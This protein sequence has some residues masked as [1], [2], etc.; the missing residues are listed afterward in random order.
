MIGTR[1]PAVDLP[2]ADHATI[3][4]YLA[5]SGDDNPLHRLP[6]LA[7]AAGY[8]DI[9]VPGMLIMGQ[10]AEALQAWPTCA[11]IDWILCRFVDP[12]V[13]G[14]ALRCEG[15]ILAADPSGGVV[16]RLTAGVG[17]RYSVVCEAVIHL[18]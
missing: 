10:M 7:Q 8:S 15:R 1:L 16:V 12:V 18:A 6:D 5:A 17:R 4:A 9:L 11:A 2:V 14:T 13:V 3:A